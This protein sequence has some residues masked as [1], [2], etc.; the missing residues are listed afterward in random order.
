MG[1]NEQVQDL[2]KRVTY[3][4]ELLYKAGI[5]VDKG[6]GNCTYRDLPSG[7]HPCGKCENSSEWEWSG[8]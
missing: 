6:C 7:V 2:E 1:L 3:L 4:E 5:G 8:C